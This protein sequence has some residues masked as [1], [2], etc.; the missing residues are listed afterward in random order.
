MLAGR[1]NFW[2]DA[3]CTTTD[4]ELTEEQ[5]A[6]R[7]ELA[8]VARA[9]KRQDYVDAC[10][11]GI[12]VAFDLSFEDKMRDREVVSLVQQIMY[13]YGVNNRSVR[14]LLSIDVPHFIRLSPY[15][16]RARTVVVL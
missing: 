4:Q 6:Q 1:S 5:L 12:R 8:K 11:S 7:R 15:G 10:A 14:S 2:R 3:G 16:T 9:K 13:C